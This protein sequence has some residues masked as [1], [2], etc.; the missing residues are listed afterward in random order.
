M[1]ELTDEMVTAAAE[2]IEEECVRRRG[3]DLGT[4]H[5]DDIVR[6]G[7]AAV[8]ALVER[9]YRIELR[10][11]WERAACPTCEAT[12][13]AGEISGRRAVDFGEGPQWC[14]DEWHD[15]GGEP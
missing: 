2:V 15:H 12:T 9:D 6:A 4:I 8:L 3:H 11:P 13:R 5:R 14:D 1:I 10:P 7:L